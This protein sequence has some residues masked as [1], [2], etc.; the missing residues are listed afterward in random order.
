MSP[1]YIV[2]K[3]YQKNKECSKMLEVLNNNLDKN[4]LSEA[5]NNINIINKYDLCNDTK[6]YRQEFY[7]CL[8]K[9]Q[10]SCLKKK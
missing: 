1:F 5:S 4:N 6:Y 3:Q 7:K 8:K 9:H 10:E 2:Y